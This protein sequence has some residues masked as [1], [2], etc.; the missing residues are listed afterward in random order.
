MAACRQLT[1]A[2]VQSHAAGI[3]V[4]LP[5][6]INAG[7][8]SAARC[9]GVALVLQCVAL[10]PSILRGFGNA[11]AATVTLGAV[12]ALPSAEQ[13]AC[14][15]ALAAAVAILR[16]LMLSGP[17]LKDWGASFLGARVWVKERKRRERH[18]KI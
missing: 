14:V 9:I 6:G 13:G 15:V 10:S 12:F 18:K 4:A 17:K 1:A 11:V 3:V 16:K 2:G 7:W 5:S 8:L